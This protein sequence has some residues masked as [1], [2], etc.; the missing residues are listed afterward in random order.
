MNLETK[1]VSP[2]KTPTV[3][4]I[5]PTSSES[6]LIQFIGHRQTYGFP[7]RDLQNLSFTLTA[8]RSRQPKR[9]HQELQLFCPRVTV[10]LTGWRLELL[11]E[12]LATG[13]INCI[14]A[15]D[16]LLAN[17]VLDEPIVGEIRL[18]FPGSCESI[19]LLPEKSK[20]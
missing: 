1:S 11:L 20:S 4:C 5:E 7:K 13:K 17:L 8:I 3:A 16:Q 15:V 19:T 9:P 6:A 18:Y 12:P 10:T 14:H 2:A